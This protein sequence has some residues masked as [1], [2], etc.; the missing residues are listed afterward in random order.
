MKHKIAYC[1]KKRS[2]N[3][4]QKNILTETP[5]MCSYMSTKR[6][7]YFNEKKLFHLTHHLIHSLK[8]IFKAY[9]EGWIR[10]DLDKCD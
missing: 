3:K 4:K 10:S 5:S 7:N 2:D 1:F 6:R 9:I 8:I